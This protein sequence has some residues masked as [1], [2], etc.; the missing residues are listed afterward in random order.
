MGLIKRYLRMAQKA[1]FM[2]LRGG[3]ARADFLRKHDMLAGIGEK[4]YFYSRIL[5]ADPKLLKLGDNIVIATNVRF[6]NHDRADIMLSEIFGK[7]Y[8]KFYDCIEVG[9]NVF[10]GADVVVL[11]GVK[12]G[13]NS[14]IGAGTVVTKDLP[15]GGI[16][17]GA[18]ARCI[19]DFQN[20]IE[21]RSKNVNPE[22]D[23]RK[24]WEKFYSE[25]DNGR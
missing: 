22:K 1:Q 15:S 6:V 21:F 4:V 7:K 18:P 17:G 10:I 11:P 14:I 8:M 20:F 12:I 25:R 9:N 3:Y 23:P 2:L 24:L 13:E 19:G 5:P 16:W